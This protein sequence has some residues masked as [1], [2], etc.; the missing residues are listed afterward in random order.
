LDGSVSSDPDGDVLTYLWTAPAGVT[1]SS[2]TVANPTFT[3]PEINSNTAYTFTLVVNDGTLNSVA[4]QVVVTVKQENQA[5]VA[6]AGSDQNVNEGTLVTLNG[7]QSSD[8]DSDPLAYKWTA[9]A[10]ITLSSTTTQT[11]TFIAPEVSVNTDYIFSLVVNDGTV[12]S[13][14]DQVVITVLN[15]NKA[16][17]ANAGIDQSVN[18][19]TIVSLDGSLS[20][21]PDGNILTYKWTAPA[22]ITM[23]STTAANPTFTAPEVTKDSVLTFSLVVNDGFVNSIPATV[24]VT[25]LN[26]IK[27]GV[28]NLDYQL[29]KVYPNP[30]TGIVNLE[31]ASGKGHKTVVSVTSLVGAE[32]F[33]KEMVDVAKFQID[34][35]NQVSGVYLLKI[36][37][38]NRQY[39]RKIVFRKE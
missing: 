15:V 27:V 39:I 18:E 14:V 3:S 7:S 29:F 10:G 13:P 35:S 4:D 30:T 12:D 26:V 25:V 36:S 38:D 2:T 32:I 24:K 23:S 20:S 11:P 22:G 16:P 17:V 28:S 21:D 31:F 9:P 6:H 5:P 34:L 37:N 33:R 8:P 1:L 19:G